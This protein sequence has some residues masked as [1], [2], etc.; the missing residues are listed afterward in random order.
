MD[1]IYSL[2]NKLGSHGVMVLS[3]C[4][5]NRV[6]SRAMSVVVILSLIHI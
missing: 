5:E 3:T 4:A 2:W 1:S 6:T